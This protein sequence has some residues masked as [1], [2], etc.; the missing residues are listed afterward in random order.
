MSFVPIDNIGQGPGYGDLNADH[1]CGDCSA[2]CCQMVILP[3][4]VP[5]S[6]EEMDYIRYILGFRNMEIYVKS[7]GGWFVAV[8]QECRFLES[9]TGLCSVFGTERRPEVC[10]KYDEHT[11][12]YKP[13]FETKTE[14]DTAR[15][16]AAAW[17]R[18]MAPLEYDAKGYVTNMPDWDAI[19]ALAVNADD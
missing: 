17:E 14:V 16:D 11:C 10:S 13:T 2:P 1:P 9:N 6:H 3:Y 4:P 19:K 7:Y 15:L 8:R 18:L 5:N 12:W